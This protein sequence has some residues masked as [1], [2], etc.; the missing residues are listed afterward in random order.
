[1]WNLNCI[2]QVQLQLQLQSLSFSFSAAI[3]EQ[4][5]A[6]KCQVFVQFPFKI[7]NLP[8]KIVQI[9]LKNWQ[10]N[11]KWESWAGP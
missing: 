8:T 1:M 7:W 5:S 6:P 4:L 10:E 2:L 11:V 9:M 3:D